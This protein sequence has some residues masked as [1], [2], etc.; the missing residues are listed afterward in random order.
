MKPRFYKMNWFVRLITLGWARAVCFAPKGIYIK[1][2]WLDDKTIRCHEA[3]HWSQQ[4]YMRYW[5]FYAWYA[6]EFIIK[7]PFYLWDTYWNLCFE[8]EANANEDDPEYPE[9][10]DPYAQFYYL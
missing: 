6:L 3:I 5:G 2:R 10:R 1:E 8:R 7:F 4:F 9:K